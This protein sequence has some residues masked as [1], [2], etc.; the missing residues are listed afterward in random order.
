METDKENLEI[1][2]LNLKL[3]RSK[4]YSYRCYPRPKTSPYDAEIEE[5]E[6]KLNDD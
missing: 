3:M 2:L 1:R 6:R 4:Y 5:L